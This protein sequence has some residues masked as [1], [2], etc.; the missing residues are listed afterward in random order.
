M[1]LILEKESEPVGKIRTWQ[2]GVALVAMVLS[3]VIVLQLRTESKTRALLPTRQVDEL[4][5]L[6]KNQKLTIE[7]YERE[8]G[9]L[10]RQLNVYDRDREIVRLRMAAG[11]LP[12]T[13]KGVRVVLDDSIKKPREYEDPLFFIVHYDQLELLLNELRAAGAEAIA[14]N[15][16]R[17]SGS[18]G[19]SC[20]G[21]TILIDT[22]RFTPPFVIEAI[23]DSANLKA[24]LMMRGGFVEQQ[25]LAFN[26]RFT[27]EIVEELELPAYKGSIS[28]EFSRPVE[29]KR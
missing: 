23:G 27:I 17:V 20:A 28:F 14:V 21:T 16:Y 15:G 18:S 22:K 4:A 11:M 10:R 3:A 1:Y 26:L 12:L 24:A 9:D 13:G 6:F 25:I 29:E 19:L 2:F 7:K 5:N 8:V